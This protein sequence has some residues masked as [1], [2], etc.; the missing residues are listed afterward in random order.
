L[1]ARKYDINIRPLV[2]AKHVFYPTYHDPNKHGVTKGQ[3]FI[4]RLQ[5]L[6]DQNTNTYL[7]R[8]MKKVIEAA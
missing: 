7:F 4:E 2:P 6:Q 8:V 3:H 5:S 1:P